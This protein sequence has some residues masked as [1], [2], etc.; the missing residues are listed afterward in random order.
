MKKF[1]R[2]LA[3]VLCLAALLVLAGCEAATDLSSPIGIWTG[4]LYDNYRFLLEC[5]I[6]E[7]WTLQDEQSRL[8][9]IGAANSAVNAED[10]EMLLDRAGTFYD[11]VA[12]SPDD[13][14]HLTI[15][16][17]KAAILNRILYSAKSLLED[18]VKLYVSTLENSGITDIQYEIVDK[19]IG[20]NE[21]TCLV[22]S[23]DNNGT[24]MFMEMF[25]IKS[26]KYY[27]CVNM[28][29]QYTD[30]IAQM[31]AFFSEAKIPT[32]GLIPTA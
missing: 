12:A 4:N 15:T 28:A 7:D 9:L 32:G 3:I 10:L 20:S 6:P 17:E 1:K 8:A 19:K 31:E 24:P 29:S 21:R 30:E 23:A 22:L 18:S 11:L 16:V 2:I 25:Y 26:A 14:Q 13:N 5:E 27:C